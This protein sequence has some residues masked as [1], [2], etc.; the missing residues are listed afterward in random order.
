MLEKI[1]PVNN[2]INDVS[3]KK[4]KNAQNNNKAVTNTI[5]AYET[6]IANQAVTSMFSSAIKKTFKPAQ[7]KEELHSQIENC[8]WLKPDNY[9]LD[10]INKIWDKDVKNLSVIFHKLNDLSPVLQEKLTVSGI[11]FDYNRVSASDREKF[12][13][14]FSVDLINQLDENIQ[15]QIK[16]I[17][18][19]LFS[20]YET[21]QD[22]KG[23]NIFYNTLDD[24]YKNIF[25][26]QK[27]LTKRMKIL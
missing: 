13:N 4:T 15:K 27:L 6:S 1:N 25:K 9:D 16:N 11:I 5:S 10:C 26:L 18:R 2:Q 17:S 12:T 7:T 21:I 3:V 23:V 22:P 20:H 14:N 8:K 24:K 19:I